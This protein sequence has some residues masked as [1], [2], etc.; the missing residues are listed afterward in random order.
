MPTARADA[1]VTHCSRRESYSGGPGFTL[2]EVTAVLIIIALLIGGVL[3]GRDLIRASRVRTQIGQLEGFTQAL[4]AFRDKYGSIPG[5][6]HADDAAAMGFTTRSGAA[7]H[8]DGNGLLE[9][10]EAF[11]PFG[12]NIPLGCEVLL[13]WSDLADSRLITG[14]FPSAEDDY[15]SIATYEESLGYFPRAALAD[16]GTVVPVRCVQGGLYYRLMR[17]SSLINFSPAIYAADAHNMDS[18]IDDGKP[19]S[20]VMQV[21]GLG[22]GGGEEHFCQPLIAST[23]VINGTYNVT[24]ASFP[25]CSPQIRI[26]GL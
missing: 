24:V 22:F 6:L 16:R 13:F 19:G 26:P 8:G 15:L 4:M 20:G 21:K 14:A 1:A 5:D 9:G 25:V 18:K 17:V 7:G 11:D 3:V 2:L 23:C 10:C 12:A